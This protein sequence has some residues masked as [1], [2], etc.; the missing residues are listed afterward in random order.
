M[1]DFIDEIFQYTD[2]TFETTPEKP[3][4]KFQKIPRGRGRPSI[5][6]TLSSTLKTPLAAPLEEH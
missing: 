4:E 2:K 1:E 5:A 6:K 3:R